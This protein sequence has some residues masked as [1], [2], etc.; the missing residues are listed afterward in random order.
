MV[1][2]D[3]IRQAADAKY[4]S[5]D[6]ELPDG[7]VAKLLNPL[8]LS[9]QKRAELKAIQGE[10]S[11]DDEDGEDKDQVD[12]FERAIRCVAQHD[13]QADALLSLVNR[14]LAIL[15]EI[16]SGYGENTQVGEAS[17]SAN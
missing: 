15:A 17:A 3:S 1:T 13:K 14:D 4:G 5:F 10:L 6:I 9:E 7:S 2:L 8:R 12:I 11:S 16:F